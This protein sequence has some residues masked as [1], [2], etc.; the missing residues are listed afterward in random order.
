MQTAGLTSRSWPISSVPGE[1]GVTQ[2]QFSFARIIDV[3]AA[4]FWIFWSAIHRSARATSAWP[5]SPPASSPWRRRTSCA[6]VHFDGLEA[7]DGIGEQD[8]RT[9]GIALEGGQPASNHA[10]RRRGTACPRV[11]ACSRP[12]ATARSERASA[13]REHLSSAAAAI[14]ARARRKCIDVRMNC[15][16][17]RSERPAPAMP[18]GSGSTPI[19]RRRS[20]ARSEQP[21][22]AASLCWTW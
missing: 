22:R 10:R 21:P 2:R 17:R 1:T 4:G 7:L 12:A 3:I 18:G 6:E 14:A 13:G 11:P 8:R 16:R 15:T 19:R 20:T 5:R 9:R